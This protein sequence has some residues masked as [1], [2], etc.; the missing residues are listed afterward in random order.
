MA[1]LTPEEFQEKHARRLKASL[2]DI[3]RGINLVTENP[4][5]KAI[6]QKDKMRANLTESIDSGKW[7]KGLAKVTVDSWKK[8]MLEKGVNRIAG[9][10]DR[11]KEDVIDFATQILPYIDEAKSKIKTMPS[12]TFEDNI[13]RMTAFSRKMHDFKRR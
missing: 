13:E 2:E 11:A 6:A 3:R 9:G 12:T 4:A 10:I 5:K 8:D 1:K 7:E